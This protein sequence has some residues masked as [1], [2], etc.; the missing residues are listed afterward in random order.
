MC[1]KL[2]ENFL[3]SEKVRIHGPVEYWEKIHEGNNKGNHDLKQTAEG[4]WERKGKCR[5][6][7]RKERIESNALANVSFPS[8]FKSRSVGRIVVSTSWLSFLTV[9]KA[10]SFNFAHFL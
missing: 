3:K 2:S 10:L 7:R 1:G 9:N 4:K 6:G 5:E 8:L